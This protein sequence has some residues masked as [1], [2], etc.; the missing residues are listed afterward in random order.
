VKGLFLR[1]RPLLLSSFSTLFSGCGMRHAMA[2]LALWMGILSPAQTHAAAADALLVQ[3]S[4]A[5]ASGQYQAAQSL[6]AAGLAETGNDALTTRRLLVARGL[7]FQ[8]QGISQ[9]ALVDF[10]RALQGDT[11]AGEERA[12]ALFARGVTLDMQGR[13]DLAMGDYT[14]ALSFEPRA[15]D[16]L[17]N[18]A[19]VHRRQGR[20]V[21]AQRDYTAALEANTSSPQYPWYGLGQIAE[22]QG[23]R[24]AAQSFYNRALMADPGFSLARKA[25]EALGTVVE[26]PAGL[27]ADTGIIVLRPPGERAPEAPILLKPPP[28]EPRGTAP[29]ARTPSRTPSMMP[30]AE[31]APPAQRRP[32]QGAPLRPAIVET[33]PAQTSASGALVQLG[34]WRSVLEAQA[35]WEAARKAAGGLLEGLAPVIVMA[36]LPGRGTYYR[37]RVRVQGSAGSFCARLEDRGLACIPARN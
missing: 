25:L 28:D 32:G 7:A 5:L 15:T 6:A 24:P 26:G 33:A 22:A 27:A 4:A 9:E 37:L 8:A 35:G 19:N 14:A 13:L 30:V 3:S 16:A 17:N 10:T 18:R 1:M 2:L 21:E 12:R 34:A 36:V 23:D 20:L 11:L 31:P 29:V